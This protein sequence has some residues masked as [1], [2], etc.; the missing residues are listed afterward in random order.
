[1]D[2]KRNILGIE[3]QRKE[4]ENKPKCWKSGVI[5]FLL[6]LFLD[7]P[8]LLFFFFSGEAL[9]TVLFLLSLRNYLDPSQKLSPTDRS[10]AFIYVYNLHSR[11]CIVIS[12]MPIRACAFYKLQMA[13]IRKHG[14]LFD[15]DGCVECSTSAPL[16]S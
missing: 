2:Y 7:E 12:G 9:N 4:K 1:M 16:I 15:P 3:V 11:L 8:F 14:G 10:V 5:W 6:T 13:D